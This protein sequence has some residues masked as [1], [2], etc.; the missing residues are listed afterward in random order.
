M[1]LIVVRQWR[2]VPKA[3]TRAAK[4]LLPKPELPQVHLEEAQ[5]LLIK[6]LQRQ[7]YGEVMVQLEAGK[8]DKPNSRHEFVIK[9]KEMQKLNPFV[10][11][12]SILR[13]GSRLV[14]GDISN[15]AKFPFILPPKDKNVK[16]LIRHVDHN[17]FHAGAKHTLCQLRRFAWIRKGL[18][19]VKSVV[20]SCFVCQ[21]NFKKTF[22]PADG[23]TSIQSHQSSPSVRGDRVGCNGTFRRENERKSGSQGVGGS[24]YLFCLP[25]RPRGIAL[26][27]VR[28]RNDQRHCTLCSQGPGIRRFTSDCGTNLI[29]ANN[30]LKKEMEEWNRLSTLHLQRRGI[31]WDFITPRMSHY[32]GVWERMVAPFKRHL[33]SISTGTT[34]HV[35]TF[36]SAVIEVEGILNR[37]PLTALSDDPSNPSALTPNHILSLSTS[38]GAPV[39]LLQHGVNFDTES[40]HVQWKGTQSRVDAFWKKWCVEYLSLLHARSK[41][42]KSERDFAVDDLVIIVD[43]AVL[44][45]DWSPGR[46]VHVEKTSPHVRRVHMRFSDKRIVTMDRTKIVRLEMDS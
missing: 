29:G 28:R 37:R 35:D 27:H 36:N 2:M 32:G 19:A 14:N 17:D 45:H 8:I 23:T 6:A 10:N 25:C 26:Q 30:I 40:A 3:K 24:F 21:R 9:N 18:L 7:Q 13:V 22:E 15:E 20:H 41:W 34:L 43:E 1:L 42:R 16:S 4:D 12:D 11:D 46:V 5:K 38:E 33:A 44:R 31:Q 39:D